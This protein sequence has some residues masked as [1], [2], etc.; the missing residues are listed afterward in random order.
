[1]ELKEGYKLTEAGVV[2]ENWNI[3]RIIDCCEYAD[4]RGKTPP[5]TQSGTFLVTARNVRMGYID[6]VDSQ[7]FV[8]TS[9][10]DQIMRR[11]KPR[12]GDVLITTEAPLGN[13]AQIDREDVAL[14][15]RI[16]KY[17]PKSDSLSSTYLKHYFLSSQ[18]QQ[19]L[20]DN[21]SGSTAKGIKGR[22][23]HQ[24]PVVLPGT[25]EQE[26]IAEAL[27][28]ADA[29]IES[30]E[31]LIAKKRQI[32]QGAMQE[33]LTGKKRLP[34]FRSMANYKESVVGRI[35]NDW[36]AIEVGAIT[37][38]HRQG[39]YTKDRYV[40][41]GVRLV[42]ITDLLNPHVDYATMP[43]LK[44]ATSDHELYRV[45]AGDFLFA[46]SGAI[47]RY[48]IVYENVD[49]VFGSYIIRFTFDSSRI[50]NE[51][52]GY[53]YETEIV[54]NQ[55]LSI[56]QGSSNININAANIKSLSIPLPEVDEQTAIATILSDMDA[57]IA[58]LETKLAKAR[59]VKQGMMQELLTGNIRLI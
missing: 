22:I 31:Q 58:A 8:P 40:D 15:Q 30:L 54:W 57:E 18:F 36:D 29:L 41:Q 4:Y 21:S 53:L 5:K 1:M 26:A 47:G 50:S 11:G 46:R 44:I 23:L 43:M 33:L 39:Y 9:L 32:K 13:V 38:T 37:V 7:E 35:P 2:P 59:Q 34:G 48:A 6:Y 52:F 25:A 14:A 19:I 20:D 55:L 27:S 17:R 56:T 45:H 16:I 12:I 49:A 24:L 42:R 28:D 10:Y 51:F 3:E